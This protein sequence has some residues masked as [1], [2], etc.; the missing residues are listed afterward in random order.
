MMYDEHHVFING[1]SYRATGKD[2]RLMRRL[3]DERGLDSRA[4][5][6]AGA[7]A[8]ALLGEWFGAGWLHARD[9]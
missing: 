4:V 1:D 6:R 7:A 9:D 5:R 2:A 3:A 8:R